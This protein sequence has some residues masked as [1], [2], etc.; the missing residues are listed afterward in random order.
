MNKLYDKNNNIITYHDLQDK[1][2]W[3][4]HGCTKEESFVNKFGVNFGV[5]INPEKENNKY[6]PDLFDW[7]D[8]KL[9]DLK[10]QNTPFFTA[11]RYGLDPQHTVTFNV[12]D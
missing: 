2:A 3:C 4:Q 6:A 8:Y 9:A 10:T 5:L 1:G 11:S 7:R 12:K